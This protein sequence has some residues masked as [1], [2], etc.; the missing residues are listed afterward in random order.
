MG[1]LLLDI[2]WYPQILVSVLKIFKKFFKSVLYLNAANSGTPR[3]QFWIVPRLMPPFF[4]PGT[5]NKEVQKCFANASVVHSEEHQ[6][7]K[8]GG[9]KSWCDWQMASRNTRNCTLPSLDAKEPELFN[10]LSCLIVGEYYRISFGLKMK[11]GDFMLSFPLSICFSF[12]CGLNGRW[13][14]D[15][16]DTTVQG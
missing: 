13:F 10:E 11:S 9:C 5:P 12:L 3:S 6:G 7:I 8:E 4:I 2:Y 14:L 1:D 15:L 16:S